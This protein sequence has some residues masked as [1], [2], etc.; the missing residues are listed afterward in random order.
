MPESVFSLVFVVLALLT[1]MLQNFQ[2][3]RRLPSH[4][5]SDVF[6][7]ALKTRRIWLGSFR[8]VAL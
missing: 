5:R 3:L 8:E 7:G 4:M 1:T 2:L 6:P